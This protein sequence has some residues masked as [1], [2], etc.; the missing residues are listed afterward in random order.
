MMERCRMGVLF[1]RVRGVDQAHR[2]ILEQ[3]GL[4]VLGYLE[5]EEDVSR[6]DRAGNA[7][8]E[9]GPQ[10]AIYRK[11]REILRGVGPLAT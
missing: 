3:A 1:N 9:L 10:T 2:R 11:L 8:Q 7:L 6:A 4:S 5:P